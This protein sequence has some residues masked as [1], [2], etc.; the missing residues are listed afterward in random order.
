MACDPSRR[1]ARVFSE[2][3][4][5]AYTAVRLLCVC[6]ARP[7]V[8]LT[9]LVCGVSWRCNTS[10]AHH[11]AM[12][13]AVLLLHAICST[14]TDSPRQLQPT[15]SSYCLQA[16]SRGKGAHARM[17]SCMRCGNGQQML[18]IART[19][20]TPPPQHCVR[21]Q[22]SWRRSHQ[23]APS[24]NLLPTCPSGCGLLP[25]APFCL[26]SNNYRQCKN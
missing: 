26:C 11:W 4:V 6:F 9:L 5:S 7:R 8:R 10:S 19:R 16:G 18:K 2:C 1:S 3:F 22:T 24:G 21:E 13:H 23:P 12:G 25:S 15:K 14:V 20:K 17:P